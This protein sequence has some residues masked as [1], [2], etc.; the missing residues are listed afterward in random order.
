MSPR[1]KKLAVSQEGRAGEEYRVTTCTR[2]GPSRC[3]VVQFYC[4]LWVVHR[5]VKRHEASYPKSFLQQ[6]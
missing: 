3:S 1:L 4:L 5:E 6:G 2:A